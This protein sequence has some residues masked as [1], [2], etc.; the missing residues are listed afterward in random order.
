MT[1]E[2]LNDICD[3]RVNGPFKRVTLEEL[4]QP[5]AEDFQVWLD[6]LPSEPN[7][8]LLRMY[9]DYKKAISE[10]RL[11]IHSTLTMP[12]DEAGKVRDRL[13]A[14]TVE[15]LPEDW[16]KGRKCPD[17]GCG[18]NAERP[19][20]LFDLGGHCP[21]HNPHEYSPSPYETR[22]DKDCKAGADLITRLL[23]QRAADAATIQALRERLEISHYWVVRDGEMV[24][25]EGDPG[26]DGIECRDATIALLEEDRA[27]DAARIEALE[28]ERD[29]HRRNWEKAFN[30]N[31]ALEA[32]FA[33]LT[34]QVERM[35]GAGVALRDDM[36]ERARTGIDA[37]HG[38]EYRIVNAGRTAWAD[39]CAAITEE[40]K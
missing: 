24:R 30:A 31:T 34:A 5:E 2:E 15:W 26:V 37:I 28:A 38:E 17:D 7:P 9:E 12:D 10:G 33:A 29:E 14:R 32:R 13:A 36:L 21:R 16:K 40:P 20:C 39:F 11:K 4:T 19:K 3:R 22:P 27:A 8:K 18:A 6:S 23:A 1:D 25:V 35:R